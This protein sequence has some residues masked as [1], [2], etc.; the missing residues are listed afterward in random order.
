MRAERIGPVVV[1]AETDKRR[2]LVDVSARLRYL[3]FTVEPVPAVGGDP[4]SLWFRASIRTTVLQMR[5]RP[6]GQTPRQSHGTDPD[7]ASSGVLRLQ[8]GAAR[9]RRYV[10]GCGEGCQLVDS[11]QIGSSYA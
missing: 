8:D 6:R 4:L 7:D 1:T 3:R 5:T 10:C 2:G 11:L 9:E